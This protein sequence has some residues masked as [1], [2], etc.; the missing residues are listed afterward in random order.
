M[1]TLNPSAGIV[2]F[3]R[4]GIRLQCADGMVRLCFPIICGFSIDYE[5]QVVVTGVKSGEHCPICE[6]PPQE[7]QNLRGKW[8][9]RTHASTQARIKRQ[10]ADNL[11]I[12]E[13]MSVHD[14]ANFAWEHWHVNIHETMMLDILHQL[15]KGLAIY[16]KDWVLRTL[17]E[18][19]NTAG[20][21]QKTMAGEKKSIETATI[22]QKLDFRFQQVSLFTGLKHFHDRKFSQVKQ[23]TGNEYRDMNRQYAAVVT[24]LLMPKKPDVMAFVRA[25]LDFITLAEY[26]SHTDTSLTYLTNALERIHDTIEQFR[27]LR[28]SVRNVEGDF[29]IPKL[30]ALTHYVDWIKLYGS[31]VDMSTS[32]GENAH[33][34]LIKAYYDRT[35]K[36]STFEQQIFEHNIRRVNLQAM[37]GIITYRLSTASGADPASSQFDSRPNKLARSTDFDQFEWPL[38]NDDATSLMLKRLPSKQWRF[39]RQVEAYTGIEDLI[40]ALAVFIRERRRRHELGNVA[41]AHEEDRR[42]PDPSW[43]RDYPLKIHPSLE[44]FKVDGKDVSDPTRR[45]P[46]RIRCQPDWRSSKKWRRDYVWVQEYSTENT[47]REDVPEYVKGKLIGQ[48]MLLVTVRD[49]AHRKCNGKY[50]EYHA[51]LLSTFRLRHGGR[52]DPVHGMI[53]I[54]IPP[55]NTARSPRYLGRNRFYDLPTI[56]RSAHIV[57]ATLTS[58][59]IFYVNNYIDWDQYNTLYDPDW[60]TRGKQIITKVKKNVAKK[61]V[62][63]LS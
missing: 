5:E 11:S 39:A 8:P 38:D 36:Q 35:N 45:V 63:K 48:V 58:G 14:I 15:Y 1:L 29:N 40:D 3:S 27:H 20:R 2:P 21:R 51:A 25:V 60:M 19:P 12:K 7:R 62:N 34:I 49:M 33:K 53:E 55:K 23:W 26:R 42:E 61:R 47:A 16:M 41:P 32:V 17:A 37:Q 43:V 28:I 6:V 50:P 31:A 22:E 56:D 44:C 46:E 9:R 54:E 13:A 59:T 52:P 18:D 30:H 24:P 10:R 57:P 4:Q